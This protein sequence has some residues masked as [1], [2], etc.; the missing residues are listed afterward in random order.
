[1]DSVRKVIDT[2]SYMQGAKTLDLLLNNANRPIY[3]SVMETALSLGYSVDKAQAARFH[4]SC[5][6]M[7]DYR[8]LNEVDRRLKRLIELKAQAINEESDTSEL[9]SEISALT[10][11]RKECTRPGGYIKNFL[12]HDKKAYYRMNMA[13]KRFLLRAETDGHHEAVAIIRQNLKRGKMFRLR[14]E[15]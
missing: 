15:G 4:E 1:M 8:T 14:D 13:I 12:D 6:P 7:T 10:R 2:Y 11:Y 3:A 9:D 5:I